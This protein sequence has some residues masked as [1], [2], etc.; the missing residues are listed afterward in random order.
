MRLLLLLVS[1]LISWLLCECLKILFSTSCVQTFYR[2][3]WRI[4]LVMNHVSVLIRSS[5]TQMRNKKNEFYFVTWLSTNAGISS[6]KNTFDDKNFFEKPPTT[7]VRETIILL[8]C[9]KKKSFISLYDCIGTCFIDLLIKLITVL[10]LVLKGSTFFCCM[11][12]LFDILTR[13]V[14]IWIFFSTALIFYLICIS[15]RRSA[16]FCF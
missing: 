2:I 9:K 11:S 6:N 16:G 12:V 5:V 4:F 13:E 3:R 8:H 14:V 15:Y 10:F 1:P 7:N